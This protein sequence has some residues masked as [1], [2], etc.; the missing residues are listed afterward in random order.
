MDRS[1]IIDPHS[2]LWE[3]DLVCIVHDVS[4]QYTKDGI[5]REMLKCLFAHPEK[6][7]ILILN[8][9]DKLKYKNV[10]LGKYGI[11]GNILYY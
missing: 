11:F 7:T 6:E 9:T 4:D 10:L 1:M 5:D 8:K 2:S 3:A